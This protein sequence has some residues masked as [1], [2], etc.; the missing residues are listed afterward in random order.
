MK[1]YTF[2]D[3]ATQA[4]T[5]LVGLLILLCHNGTVANWQSL[6][7]LHGLLAIGIHL[8]IVTRSRRAEKFLELLR[9]FYPVLLYAFFFAETGW[10]NRMFFSGYMDE[11]IVWFEQAVFHCQP[12]VSFMEKL[13]YLAVSE[14]FYAAY[15]SYYVMIAGVGFALFVRNRHQFFHYVSVMSFIFYVCYLAYIIFPIVGP[16]IF[17][18][19]IDGFT[20]TPALQQ[21]AGGGTPEAIRQGLFYKLVTWLYEVFEAP[22]AAFP[23]SHV[24]ISWCT[25]YFSFLY[26]PRI[27]YWHLAM[28]I[29][30]TL[31]T[32]YCRYHYGVDVLAG[33]LTVALLVPLANR[34]YFST[35][36]ERESLAQPQGANPPLEPA[37]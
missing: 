5:L 19:P 7:V 24:A 8:A 34:L 12:S 2:V 35:V 10:I 3:Y 1:H 30:L 17:Y 15:F 16:P 27:R 25:T 23:S 28:T 32:V 26:L 11:P 14:V 21:L 33:G 4:Y 31:A 9:H 22:G 37:R 18:K 13:P 29:L 36:Q 20:L 6:V